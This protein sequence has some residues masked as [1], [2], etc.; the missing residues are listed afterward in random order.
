MAWRR[1][2]DKICN[3]SDNQHEINKAD[4][5]DKLELDLKRKYNIRYVFNEDNERST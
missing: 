1:L 3:K 2:L 4:I 5:K